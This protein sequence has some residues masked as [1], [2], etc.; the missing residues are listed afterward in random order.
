MEENTEKPFESSF[1]IAAKEGNLNDV[2]KYFKSLTAVNKKEQCYYALY[3]AAFN[4]HENIIKF[5]ISKKV[6]VNFTIKDYLTPLHAATSCKYRDKIVPLL[7][8]AGANVNP[9]LK[10][11]SGE[12]TLEE[13][14]FCSPL[15][16]AVK[17][18]SEKIV[19]VLLEN[20]ANVNFNLISNEKII[21][22]LR[23]DKEKNELENKLK[24]GLYEW[25]DLQIQSGFSPLHYAISGRNENIA[26]ILIRAGADLNSRCSGD[27]TPLCLSCDI[28]NDISLLKILLEAGSDINIEINNGKNILAYILKLNNKY[29]F[30]EYYDDHENS[31][32]T[33]NQPFCY[34]LK[35]GANPNAWSSKTGENP[36]HYAAKNG[37]VHACH[38][39]IKYGANPN[40]I[41]REAKTP[42]EYSTNQLE[43]ILKN[44]RENFSDPLH[45][46]NSDS[47]DLSDV[48]DDDL[49]ELIIRQR[50]RINNEKSSENRKIYNLSH[51]KYEYHVWEYKRVHLQKVQFNVFKDPEPFKLIAQLLLRELV[52][53][54]SKG[55]RVVK[56]N[57]N[58]I[59]SDF[60]KPYYEECSEEL[61]KLK[62]HFIVEDLSYYQFLMAEKSSIK[63]YMKNKKIKSCLEKKYLD[64][65]FPNYHRFLVINSQFGNESSK[66]DVNE[67]KWKE[68]EKLGKCSVQIKGAL[69]K[70]WN[71]TDGSSS[72]S[73][74]LNFQW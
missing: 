5:L 69:M 57:Q 1:T 40:S 13:K 45:S 68:M 15:H 17:S 58:L 49:R 59:Q 51:R 61:K 2:K 8:N 32:L 20:K 9:K 56:Q 27:L 10:I 28:N 24:F 62:N 52:R 63:E 26:K 39:L 7:I 36:I 14:Y 35:I 18:A 44:I 74:M 16:I 60:V 12:E 43:N 3:F 55:I 30:D 19:G 37:M 25:Y 54:E 21:S 66:F 23:N 67:N 29:S 34:L 70:P 38:I 47:S 42:L 31:W 48:S 50:R 71:Y 4:G 41:D 72:D 65:Y 11:T 46:E 64:K 53:L 6:D 73:D 33:K 22:Q